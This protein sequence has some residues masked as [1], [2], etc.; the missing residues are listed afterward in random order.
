MYLKENQTNMFKIIAYLVV[1]TLFISCKTDD[2][3]TNCSAVSCAA[4]VVVF[5]FIDDTTD[6]NYILKNNITKADIQIQN[7]ANNQIELIF[8][9]TTGV[10]FISKL[11][12]S[13]T[14]LNIVLNSNSTT[15]IS[16]TVGSSKTNGC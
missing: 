15:N 16:Y 14:T 2:G 9:E 7:C 13:D 1:I 6:E 4:P 11:S 3:L 10:L 5:N 8:D 12:T